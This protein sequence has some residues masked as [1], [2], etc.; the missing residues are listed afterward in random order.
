MIRVKFA[1]VTDEVMSPL[2]KSMNSNN[3]FEIMG[4]IIVLMWLQLPR[5]I[6]HYM[7]ILHQHT[8]EPLE[9]S[10]T[11]DDK[12]LACVRKDKHR[13]GGYLSFQSLEAFFCLFLPF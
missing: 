11:I 4:W 6:G 13:V 8:A 2:L 1:T 10:V 9:R 12:V 3:G 7:T 5:S